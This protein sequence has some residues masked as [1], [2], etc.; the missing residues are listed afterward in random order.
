MREHPFDHGGDGG[1]HRDALLLDG[2]HDLAGVESARGEDQPGP[3]DE[4][5]QE[6]LDGADVEER[7]ARQRDARAEVIGDLMGEPTRHHQEA[8]H[9]GD[10]RPVGERRALREA[11]RARRE[12]DDAGA[13]LVS[14]ACTCVVS[15]SRRPSR[16]GSRRRSPPAPPS[17]ARRADA[18]NVDRRP[19]RSRVS[20]ART[21]APLRPPTTSR[22]RGR[23]WRR[24]RAR[25]RRWPT[26]QVS[27][28]RT[29]PP[30][31]RGQRHAP[32]V[33]L[34]GARLPVRVPRTSRGDRPG[35]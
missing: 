9:V 12:Q 19:P 13:V 31:R 21:R 1:P 6:D 26:T 23:R 11:G 20:S 32:P 3:G 14:S 7:Q 18:P 2:A 10:Q 34:R 25:R 24:P 35:R 5:Q 33:A 16:A 15:R 30:V 29:T 22:C 28:E 4:R 8:L 17:P 27:W